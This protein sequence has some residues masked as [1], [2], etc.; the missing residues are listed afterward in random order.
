MEPKRIPTENGQV[1]I[2]LLFVLVGLF[3][4]A[5]LAI[6]ISMVY[7]D[8]RI[9]QNAAD[10]AS[11]A[12]AG[13]AARDLIDVERG[14]W[15][16]SET[17]F[18]TASEAAMLAAEACAD[19]NDFVTVDEDIS[20]DNGIQTICVEDAYQY[21]DVLIEIT[22]ETETSF[23]HLFFNDPLVNTVAA[24][25]RVFPRWPIFVDMG[26]VS[27]TELC[28]GFD[29]GVV[30]G[31]VGGDEGLNVEVIDGGIFSHSCL[32][33]NGSSGGVIAETIEYMDTYKNEMDKY[34]EP[35][36]PEKVDTGLDIPIIDPGC[37][38][39]A[40][41]NSVPNESTVELEP[42]RYDRIKFS[43]DNLTLKPGLYCVDGVFDFTGTE[44]FGDGVTIAIV[45]THFG[46]S[47]AANSKVTLKAPLADCKTCDPAIPGLLLWVNPLNTSTVKL[48]GTSDSSF[49]GTVFAPGSI[50]EIIGTGEL[51]SI[52]YGTQIIGD[53]IKVTGSGSVDIIYN[54]DYIYYTDVTLEVA[55]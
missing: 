28:H 18:T 44:L 31:G 3:A 1:L 52:D 34:I 11:L 20:D 55:R 25:A 9:G 12:G 33:L 5:A 50:I 14:E 54:E 51:E 39:L 29:K 32:T 30:I 23:A 46:F 2:L 8:R 37:D 19:D 43:K 13:A 49:Y 4:F 6:D 15:D 21:M 26:I 42:G 7:S 27:L 45:S 48:S 36:P 47:T 24:V 38:P 35:D 10:S 22:Q 40:P 53:T 16:C 41:V 17:I